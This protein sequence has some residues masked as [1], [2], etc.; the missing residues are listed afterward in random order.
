MSTLLKYYYLYI[1]FFQVYFVMVNSLIAALFI[2]TVALT[3]GSIIISNHLRSSYKADFL[4]SLLFYQVF[5][6]SFGFYAIWGQFIV[7]S[8]LSPFISAEIIDRIK[9][10]TVLLGLPF[11]ALYFIMF[12]RFSRGI[13]GKITGRFFIIGFLVLNTLLIIGIG[14]IF[15]NYRSIDTFIIVKYYFILIALIF[16]IYAAYCMLSGKRTEKKLTY[17]DKKLMSVGMFALL[18]IQIIAL[19]FYSG[20]IYLALVFILFYFLNG[21]FIPLFLRYYADLSILLPKE[22]LGKSFE[23]FCKE[24]EI[25]KRETEIIYEI[26]KGLTNQQIADKLFISLQTVKDHTSRIYFKT[27]SANRAQLIR[28]VSDSSPSA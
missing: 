18:I 26:C 20:N 9:D 6:F 12:I 22:E 23:H 24:H 5:Y 4:P 3:L 19:F 14:Y 8:I 15:V 1:K 21:T 2:L 28:M 13:A 17:S 16:T 11:L 7:A 10:L 27:S 25:S